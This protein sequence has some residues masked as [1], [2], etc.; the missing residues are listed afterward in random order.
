MRVRV[1]GGGGACVRVLKRM[2][3]KREVEK[4]PK[5]IAVMLVCIVKR[6]ERCLIFKE[7]SHWFMNGNVLK[8]KPVNS[9]QQ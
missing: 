5:L 3:K 4:I 6:T 2:R 1:C 8:T 7:I 9:Y